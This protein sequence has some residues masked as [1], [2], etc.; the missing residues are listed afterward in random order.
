MYGRKRYSPIKKPIEPPLP[1][2]IP[3]SAIP[4]YVCG[5]CGKIKQFTSKT[6]TLTGHQDDNSLFLV[7]RIC[8]DCGKLLQEWLSK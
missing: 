3:P 7:V 2:V 4:T 6:V 5:H 8:E 1:S